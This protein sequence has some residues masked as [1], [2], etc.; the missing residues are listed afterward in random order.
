MAKRASN[1]A[2]KYKHKVT[3]QVK[4]MKDK[5]F[6]LLPSYYHKNTNTL[7]KNGGFEKIGDASPMT[8][9]AKAIAAGT[10][11]TILADTVRAKNQAEAENAELKRKLAELEANQNSGPTEET[12]DEKAA[13]EQAE[14]ETAQRKSDYEALLTKEKTEDGLTSSEKRKFKKLAKEFAP[15]EA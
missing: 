9:A 1:K 6:L 8:D 2:S 12:E 7:H 4:V 11:P 10:D 13:R 14:A 5:T 3:G 15:N